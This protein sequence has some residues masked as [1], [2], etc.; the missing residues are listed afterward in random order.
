MTRRGGH[1]A[2][3]HPPSA[4]PGDFPSIYLSGQ[5]AGEPL[6]TTDAVT[7]IFQGSGSQ[8]DTDSRWGAYSSVALDGADLCSFW[9]TNQYYPAT[10]SFAWNTGVAGH[11]RFSGCE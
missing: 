4:A 8:T 7:L 11:I 1:L 6:D 5:T 10:G 3:L 2:R 9:Y